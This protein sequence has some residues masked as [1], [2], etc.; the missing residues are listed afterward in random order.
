MSAGRGT[1]NG[2]NCRGVAEALVEAMVEG[3][4]MSSRSPLLF[5]VSSFFITDDDD[6]ESFGL[7]SKLSTI[8]MGDPI[9]AIDALV[10]RINSSHVTAIM[11]LVLPPPAK[12]YKSEVVIE[13]KEEEEEEEEEKEV[14]LCPSSAEMTA[15]GS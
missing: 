3:G 1:L 13:I 15:F 10:I 4:G 12:T 8:G 5:L 9:S 6:D 7:F 14:L 2:S 11:C